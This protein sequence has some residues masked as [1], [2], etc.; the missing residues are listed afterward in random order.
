VGVGRGLF[1]ITGWSNVGDI[2]G[3]PIIPPPQLEHPLD[4]GKLSYDIG[5]PP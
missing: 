1:I 3:G 2:I 5:I 4:C